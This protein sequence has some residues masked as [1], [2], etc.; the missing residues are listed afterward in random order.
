MTGNL[1]LG[2]TSGSY[3]LT[4]GSVAPGSDLRH[5]LVSCSSRLCRSTHDLRRTMTSNWQ[6]WCMCVCVCAFMC[7]WL[8]SSCRFTIPDW[9]KF[10]ARKY[11]ELNWYCHLTGWYVISTKE[12]Y[13]LQSRRFVCMYVPVFLYM[14]FDSVPGLDK[15][16]RYLHKS[17]NNGSLLTTNLI[18]PMYYPGWEFGWVD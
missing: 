10:N 9:P 6:R 18:R 14:H 4:G 13:L 15:C 17:E 1:S 11:S 12:S 16:Q 3:W 7:M 5:T 2:D 8:N